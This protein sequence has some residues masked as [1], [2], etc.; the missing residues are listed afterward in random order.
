MSNNH[1]TSVNT[2]GPYTLLTVTLV[3]LKALGYIQWSWWWVFAPIWMPMV[4]VLVIA[5][6]IFISKIVAHVID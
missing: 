3:I 4:L 5:L 1:T 2:T 6:L